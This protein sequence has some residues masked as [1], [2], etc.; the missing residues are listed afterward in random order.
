MED[1]SRPLPKGWIRQY[2][3]QHRHQFFVDTTKE[4]PRA[5]WTHPEDD[6]QYLSSLPSE[7]RERIQTLHK[8]PTPADIAAED[9]D[10]EYEAHPKK[11][12]GLGGAASSSTSPTT[13]QLP[14]RQQ[15]ITFG[16]KMKDKI[17]GMTHEQRIEE[18][19]QRAL[20]EQEM[21]RAHMAFRE[22]M[23]RAHETGVPQKVGT[24]RNGQDVYVEPP[25]RGPAGYGGYGGMHGR[26]YDPYA[27]NNPYYGNPNARYIR[28]P[29]PYGRPYGRGYG[30]GYGLPIA[31]GL[32][33]GALL[34]GLLF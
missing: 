12:G 31:G 5:I 6:E 27:Q 8:T 22:A 25:G 21:Y 19:K 18:R 7:E 26:G 3:A 4:P 10:D 11:T 9:T 2:D 24:D 32:L 28:P 20:Q 30:G 33:G 34:G 15:K 14:D 17:T 23:A 29:M 1:E 16:R 13:A